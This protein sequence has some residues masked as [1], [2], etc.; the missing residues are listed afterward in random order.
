MKLVLRL[1]GVVVLLLALVGGGLQLAS[2][3]GEVVTLTSLDEA[4]EPATTRLWVV[5]LDGYQYLRSGDPGSGWYQRLVANPN[6]KVE[7]NGQEASYIA[8]PDTSKVAQVND[9][10]AEKYG[11]SETYIK[12]VL[13]SRDGSIPVRLEPATA[14]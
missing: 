5:D 6:V 8:V 7:R 3:T 2:E 14:P 4:G 10:M 11:L 1:V 13:G 9:L 12:T